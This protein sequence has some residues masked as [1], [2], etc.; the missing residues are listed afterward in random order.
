M[1][2]EGPKS[3][4]DCVEEGNPLSETPTLDCYMGKT[5]YFF[6]TLDIESLGCQGLLLQHLKLP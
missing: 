4:N 2:W 5:I 3:L 1:R 6:Y